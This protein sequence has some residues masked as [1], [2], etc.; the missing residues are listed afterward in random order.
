MDTGADDS[1]LPHYMISLL[2]LSK[3]NLKESVAQGVGESLVKTWEAKIPVTFC[4]QSFQLPCSFTDNN[5][6]PML[7]GKEGIFNRFNLT[8]QNDKQV[9]SFEL[10]KHVNN[11]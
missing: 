8:F 11:I 2:N 5:K 9:L 3:H 1:T 4:G 6:T 7:L 10:R